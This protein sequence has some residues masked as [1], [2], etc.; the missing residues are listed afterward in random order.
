MRCAHEWLHPPVAG[1]KS[2]HQLK[3]PSDSSLVYALSIDASV[4]I[5]VPLL[6]SVSGTDEGHKN[7]SSVQKR[8]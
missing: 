7:V 4:A 6:W 8:R 5:G 2:T 1:T 3:T